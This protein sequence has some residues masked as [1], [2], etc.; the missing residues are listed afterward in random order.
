MKERKAKFKPGDLLIFRIEEVH[1]LGYTLSP[2]GG[3]FPI[4]FQDMLQ[5]LQ[6]T[7][8]QDNEAL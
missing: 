1:E 6:K 5:P 7:E 4:K 3:Y 8:G 2:G